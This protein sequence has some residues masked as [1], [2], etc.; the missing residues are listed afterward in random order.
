[1]KNALPSRGEFVL[2]RGLSWALY[3]SGGLDLQLLAGVLSPACC[4]T[5]RL[6]GQAAVRVATAPN[7]RE[8]VQTLPKLR[9]VVGVRPTQAWHS[10]LYG[11]HRLNSGKE[12]PAFHLGSLSH[13]KNVRLVTPTSPWLEGVRHGRVY[14]PDAEVAGKICKA[15]SSG[16]GSRCRSTTTSGSQSGKRYFDGGTPPHYAP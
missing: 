5:A 8:Q 12:P 7:L 6:P 3:A 2:A 15:L 10:H 13:A 1:M 9:V 14:Q 11:D 16:I 4:S